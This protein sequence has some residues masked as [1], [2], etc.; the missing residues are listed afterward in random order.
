MY[1]HFCDVFFLFVPHF[2]QYDLVSITIPFYTLPAPVINYDPELSF[3]KHCAHIRLKS[4]VV[5]VVI[6]IFNIVTF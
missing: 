3:K 5:V 4:K 1:I 6:I 2:P